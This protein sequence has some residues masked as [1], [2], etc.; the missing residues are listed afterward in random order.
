M[1]NDRCV[2]YINNDPGWVQRMSLGKPN[3]RS[4][5]KEERVPFERNG[6]LRLN[7]FDKR[8]KI[9]VPSLFPDE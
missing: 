4:L 7:V 9:F 1:K 3:R 8:L 2:I 5:E 6:H